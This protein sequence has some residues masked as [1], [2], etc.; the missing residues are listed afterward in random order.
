[1]KYFNL[2]KLSSAP[3]LLC[4]SGGS[5][6]A[7]QST[8]FVRE[9]AT[10]T[11]VP[12][13][14]TD[15]PIRNFPTDT[16]SVGIEVSFS[17][18]Q[19]LL[20]NAFN[21][22]RGGVVNFDNPI[23]GDTLVDFDRTG[24]RSFIEREIN[25][26]LLAGNFFESQLERQE[27]I[28]AARARAYEQGV[29][30]MTSRVPV[31]N[32]LD[33]GLGDDVF[34]IRNEIYFDRMQIL[35][36][37]NGERQL[38][39]RRGPQNYVEGALAR[40]EFPASE[41]LSALTNDQHF[42]WVGSSGYSGGAMQAISE[43]FTLNPGMLDIAFD[44]RDNVVAL[45]FVLLSVNNFQY[46]QGLGSLPD[47]PDNIR[48]L[49][50]FSNGESEKLTSFTQQTI[51][52]WN[53]FFGLQ[54]PEGASIERLR[55]RIVGRNFRTFVLMDDFSFI[56]APSAPFLVS[57]AEATA[58]VGRNLF[59]NAIFGQEP[60]T[61][62]VTGLPPGVSY[63]P[64][65]QI[66][67]GV[68]SE[69]GVFTATFTLS[70][71]VGTTEE[72][73]VFT[74]LPAVDDA[75]VPSIT[76]A[77]ELS[78]AVTL[79]LSLSPLTV[80]TTR[81]EV[82]EPGELN[83]FTLVFRL[84]DDGSRTLVPLAASGIGLADGVFSGTPV[85][86]TSV[87]TYEVEVFVRNR[88]GG[89]SATFILDVFPVVPRPNFDGSSSTDLAWF[90][91]STNRIYMLT[92]EDNFIDPD[93]GAFS[94]GT[95]SARNTGLTAARRQDIAIAD[96][97]VNNQTD[98]A[99]YQGS[100]GRVDF[101]LLGEELSANRFSIDQISSGWELKMT[102]DLRGDGF[103]SFLWYQTATGRY[104]L[105]HFIV[106]ELVWAG[107]LFDDNLAREFLLHGDF[108]GNG[109]RELL[110]RRS[111]NSYEL[112]SA[113]IGI[114]NLERS[115][116]V[117]TMP[118]TDWI[119]QLAADFSGNAVDDLLW[120]NTFSGEFTVWLMEGAN[121]PASARPPVELDE[122][123]EPLPLPP[124][125]VAATPG[126]TLLPFG[127]PFEVIT[128][129]DVDE[130]QRLDLI[131][132]N[133]LDGSLH[134]LLMDGDAPKAPRL[135]LT[136]PAPTLRVVAT[137]D[138]DGDKREDILT[139]DTETGET[140]FH[141]L[142]PDG[143]ES[144]H[145]LGTFASAV[146]FI[147]PRFI[148]RDETLPPG[149][150]DPLPPW[151]DAEP[152]GDRWFVSPWYGTLWDPA[153]GFIYHAEHGFQFVFGESAEVGLWFFDASL[154]WL[155]TNETTY[156]WFFFP[157]FGSWILFEQGTVFPNRRF[158]E[159]ANFFDWVDESDL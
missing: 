128:A 28:N 66:V 17:D 27:F 33:Q 148:S 151:E 153:E 119:P 113:T 4:L 52:G 101:S 102:G 115:S 53:T 156:P 107:F 43:P 155:W 89:D 26:F 15:A 86:P 39:L 63:N 143:I 96:F 76:N 127:S 129:L 42:W 98:F 122:E 36:G 142:G 58:A 64:A 87:G 20:Q 112:V 120:K 40:R 37:L 12:A 48:V 159:I 32:R 85:L 72:E 93:T 84:S 47:N 141:L 117:F 118:S 145:V 16:S 104:A 29:V 125:P 131:L 150:D 25:D 57:G 80:E 77:A 69:E 111:N 45:G 24:V 8:D 60:S 14:G 11:V 75:D 146:E 55:V 97:D 6:L 106:D 114:T 95:W 51:G 110:F 7:G 137:G 74:I 54:A 13:I 135:S 3:L 83:F 140:V 88:F 154:D 30:D 50:E 108:T 103:T 152:L 82:A 38:T 41:S 78:A 126:V 21:A 62:S 138:Y 19:I 59:Y 46:W 23:Y 49:V 44:P 18:F 91:A 121:V 68:P 136:G 73:V 2:I 116:V 65:T 22:G 9:S 94:V 149:R 79:G 90:N 144:S 10:F 139:R 105:W 134:L 5:F 81:D 130:D 100:Q 132:Q 109:Q 147:T 158:F 133:R 35:Y 99:V 1:M 67:S 123:G 61:V 157:R 92:T 70:N 56:T 31:E 71:D 34:P 124:G